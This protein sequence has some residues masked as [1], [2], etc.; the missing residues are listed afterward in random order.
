MAEIIKGARI[1]NAICAELRESAAA[2]KERGIIPKLNIIRV[3]ARPDDLS[4]ERNALKRADSVG[5]AVDITELSDNASQEELLH[6]LKRASDATDVHGILLF[7]PLPQGI[8]DVRAR[9]AIIP[10]KDVDGITDASLAGV[11]CG[12]KVGFPPCT[13]QACVEM[14]KRSNIE[15]AGKNV[16]VVGRSLVIGRPVAMMLMHENATVTVCHTRTRDVAAKCR[17][18][19]IVIAASG[20]AGMI[21]ANYVNTHQT[22]I[23]VGINFTA[24]GKLVG[25]VLFDE[26]EPVVSAVTPVPGGVGSVTTAVL[27]SHVIDSA[28][29][30][31]T[32]TD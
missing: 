21:T 22:V 16:T 13:A 4:Y 3:G 5:V 18:A 20:R 24:D 15:L 10:D 29:R 17:E 27:M 1:A 28:M 14:L 6:A 26:V 11:F 23:D 7:R 32:S 12:T 31:Q 19:D 9:A 30:T 2:L 8:D 25:D